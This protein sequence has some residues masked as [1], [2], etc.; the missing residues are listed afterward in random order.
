MR[1]EAVPSVAV[2]LALGGCLSTPPGSKES[3][4]DAASAVA[5]DGSVVLDDAG[6]PV[7]ACAEDGELDLAYVSRIALG[8]DGEGTQ[9]SLANIAVFINPGSAELEATSLSAY[10]RVPAGVAASIELRARDERLALPAS[11]AHGAL[12]ML[13][14]GM[15][16]TDVPEDWTDQA[17]PRLAADLDIITAITEDTDVV[18][19]LGIGGYRFE[20]PV[21]LVP[22]V[23]AF[24]GEPLDSDRMRARCGD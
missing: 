9:F 2:C 3:A 19:D 17:Y 21:T 8:G 22:Q 16:L 4:A 6:D 24:E 14:A 12:G 23:A 15:V 11:E 18:L 7:H 1:A 20:A 13:Y 5:T 10:V